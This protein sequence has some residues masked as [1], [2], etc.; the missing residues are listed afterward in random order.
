LGA[1][2]KDLKAGSGVK[3]VW[4]EE[5]MKNLVADNPET[6][7]RNR[8]SVAANQERANNQGYLQANG[9]NSSTELTAAMNE[10]I[11]AHQDLAAAMKPVNEAMGEFDTWLTKV[12]A[13]FINLMLGKSEDGKETPRLKLGI[14]HRYKDEEPDYMKTF[15]KWMGLDNQ[16]SHSETLEGFNPKKVIQLDGFQQM[17]ELYKQYESPSF[18]PLAAAANTNNTVGGTQINA[19]I[20]VEG[21][22]IHIELNGSA[23]EEDRQKMM[24][25]VTAKLDETTAAMTLQIPEVAKKVF[26]DA[27]GMGRAQQAERQ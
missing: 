4:F 14:K 2:N 5:A 1:Y 26:T 21:A 9:I 25:A 7:D 10:N 11:K 15:S 24:S 8:K 23:T 12:Q 20:T 6:L 3:Y 27:L 16:E 13:G 17:A 19:P 22:N 18:S